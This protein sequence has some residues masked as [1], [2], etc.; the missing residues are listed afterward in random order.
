MDNALHGVT[1][2][3]NTGSPRGTD[4]LGLSCS[5]HLQ[6]L[7]IYNRS[8]SRLPHAAGIPEL[9]TAPAYQGAGL[10]TTN[11]SQESHGTFPAWC[12][13]ED[14]GALAPLFP[15]SSP[16][17]FDTFPVSLSTHHTSLLHFH[18]FIA[19][20]GT[21]NSHSRCEIQPKVRGDTGWPRPSRGV[22]AAATMALPLV[23]SCLGWVCS[24]LGLSLQH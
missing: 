13:E 17:P 16:Q 21:I 7:P 1:R 6:G 19:K 23:L 4:H 5:Y 2:R 9:P 11:R 18:G 10:P 22:G 20:A 8:L 12:W 24:P 14:P 3:V 15:P